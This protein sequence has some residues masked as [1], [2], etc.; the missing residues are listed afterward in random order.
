MSRRTV[1]QFEKAENNPELEDWLQL[2][3]IAVKH[4][5]CIDVVQV[6]VTRCDDV[7]NLVKRLNQTSYPVRGIIHS[8]VISDDRLLANLNQETLFRVMGP[9]VRGGWNL[10][11]A[12]QQTD[13]SLHFFVMFSSIRNHLIDPGS[14]GYNAG[15]EFFE[16]LAHHRREHLQL[17][18]LSVA[19]PAVS[20]AGMFHRQQTLLNSLLTAQV[21]EALETVPTFEIIELLFNMQ[22]DYSSPVIFAVDWQR[23][24][25]N[26]SNLINHQ[27]VE[28]TEKHAIPEDVSGVQANDSSS[29]STTKI[30][31]I[32]ERVRET[33]MR[34]LGG[35]SLDRIDIDRSL[36]SLGLDSLAAVSLYNWLSQEWGAFITLAD[37]FQGIKISEIAS[38]L[39]KKLMDRQA[40][41]GTTQTMS[42]NE[43][44]EVDESESDSKESAT[45][46]TASYTGMERVLRVSLVKNS[47][48]VIFAIS[49][50]N[51]ITDECFQRF[52]NKKATTYFIHVTMDKSHIESSAHATIIQMR[53]LYPRGPYSLVAVDNESEDVIKEIFK[54]LKYYAKAT[55]NN[56][57]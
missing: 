20:G 10:H 32:I 30:E 4:N 9:K 47:K 33:V 50:S 26:K 46:K 29:S 17:P 54:Q 37:I 3:E 52:S 18:A 25:A 48:S 6:D 56:I 12:S 23:L 40:G 27:L 35:S 49:S 53:R 39:Q 24:N 13:T 51:T 19:L 22:T 28:L 36:L 1:E 38:R 15:N 55:V 57:D 44:E 14:S 34:L 43:M 31:I 42:L 16:A 8:A 7:C 11:N 2:K 21:I 5:A 41:A 45:K